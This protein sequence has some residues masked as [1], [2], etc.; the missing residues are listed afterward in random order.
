MYVP[1]F[2]EKWL[3]ERKMFRYF[4]NFCI[5]TFKHSFIVKYFWKMSKMF[6]CTPEHFQKKMLW[7][8]PE[9]DPKNRLK[10]TWKEPEKCFEVLLKWI[11]KINWKVSDKCFEILLKGIWKM[12]WSAPERDPENVLKLIWEVRKM[13]WSS[14]QR[15]ENCTE[16]HLRGQKNVLKLISEVRKLY[17]SSFERSEKCTEAH[18]RGQKNV[19]KL[20]ARL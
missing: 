9:K 14:F 17:W 19:I 16:A 8:S 4:D 1:N 2:L 11:R 12:F 10:Y 20:S 15:S 7:K 13:Y 5:L 3:Q 6:L 18:L